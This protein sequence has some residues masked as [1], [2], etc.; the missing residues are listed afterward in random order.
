M[1]MPDFKQEM[2]KPWWLPIVVASV[3]SAALAFLGESYLNQNKDVHDYDHSVEQRLQ[4]S[5]LAIAT[6]NISVSNISEAE[7]RTESSVAAIEQTQTQMLGKLQ[8]LQD[9]NDAQAAVSQNIKDQFLDL[10]KQITDNNNEMRNALN[11][12]FGDM[13]SS[14]SPPRP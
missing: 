5:E 7:H 1:T 10:R 13:R 9:A 3:I 4:Q 11:S 8:S 14:R 2:V 12:I 6:L